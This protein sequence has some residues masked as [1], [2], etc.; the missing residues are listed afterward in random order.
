M[1]SVVKDYLNLINISVEHD[2]DLYSIRL[3]APVQMHQKRE[4]MER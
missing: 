2:E 3:Y 1:E 4:V